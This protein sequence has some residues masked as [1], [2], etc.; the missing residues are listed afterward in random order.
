MEI[1][2]T[3]RVYVQ[4]GDALAFGLCN[5]YGEV[6]ERIGF[7]PSY[8]ALETYC[9]ENGIHCV[10]LEPREKDILAIYEYEQQ[11]E[12]PECKRLAF[13]QE[14]GGEDGDPVYTF[15]AFVSDRMLAELAQ[16]VRYEAVDEETKSLLYGWEGRRPYDGHNEWNSHMDKLTQQQIEVYR[17]LYPEGA[18]VELAHMEEPYNPIPTGMRGTVQSIDDSGN[19]QVVWDNGRCFPLI[20]HMDAFRMLRPSELYQE[21]KGQ[22]AWLEETNHNLAPFEFECQDGLYR[23]S[24]QLVSKSG[25]PFWITRD[26]N[27]LDYGTGYDWTQIFTEFFRG[28]PALHQIQLNPDWDQFCVTSKNPRLL[29]S[30]GYEFKKLWENASGFREVADRVQSR[31]QA[32]MEICF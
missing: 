7:F 21:K 27:D 9:Q 12:I 6:N 17:V 3:A 19:I 15:Q 32:E 29:E 24:L 20:P 22:K 2:Q 1:T 8:E 4:H 23:M 11:Q 26:E 10:D 5:D 28:N 14:G 31:M 30:I 16:L 25:S 13:V 18:R